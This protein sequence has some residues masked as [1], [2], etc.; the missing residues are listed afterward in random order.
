MLYINSKR[1]RKLNTASYKEGLVVYWMHRDFRVTNNWSL[2]FAVNLSFQYKVPLKVI[3]NFEEIPPGN[4]CKQQDL[5]FA[6][7]RKIEFELN[8]I[9]VELIRAVGIM[10]ENIKKLNSAEIIGAVVAD[11][12][13][14]RNSRNAL[15]NLQKYF[16]IP[17]Y[18]VDAHNIVP[19]WHISTKEEYSAFTFRKKIQPLLAEFLDEFPELVCVKYGDVSINKTGWKKVKGN[20]RSGLN[21]DCSSFKNAETVLTAFFKSKLEKYAEKRNNPNLEVTSGLSSFLHFGFISAQSIVVELLKN[22]P[23]DENSDAFLEELVVRRE[24]SDNYCLYNP[25][26][27][28]YHGFR[29]WAKDTL[30]K[31]LTDEREY[32]Y[33]L[34]EFENGLT[35]D[36]LWNSAQKQMKLTGAMHGYMRMYWAKKI[37]EWTLSAA[38]AM[39]IAVYLNDKYSLDGNDPNGYAGC[40]WAIG[41][42]HDRPWKERAVYG[43]IRYMNYNGCKRKFDVGLYIKKVNQIEEQV[44]G[45]EQNNR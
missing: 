33:S 17:I 22:R 44:Y 24:L 9:N 4:N 3:V 40:A 31:H 30:N 39:D 41:G 32:L 45:K 2:V 6:E 8:Q 38:E 10:E 5:L 20:E 43:K 26:Y 23:H 27:D 35:H 7:L 21:L 18:E 42:V 19:A 11:F 15:L 16:H 34:T 1:V 29:D 12:G 28:N 25:D 14:L 13:P 36:D 37:L